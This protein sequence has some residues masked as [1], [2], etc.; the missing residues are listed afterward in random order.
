M[1]VRLLYRVIVKMYDMVVKNSKAW[2]HVNKALIVCLPFKKCMT[3]DK[4]RSYDLTIKVILSQEYGQPVN[5]ALYSRFILQC[6]CFLCIT[7]YKK[8]CH[9]LQRWP[10]SKKDCQHLGRGG[11]ALRY[12]K[13]DNS[14]NSPNGPWAPTGGERAVVPS[15]LPVTC[16][17][18]IWVVIDR[19]R[20]HLSSLTAVGGV[21]GSDRW[22]SPS[23]PILPS[24]PTNWLVNNDV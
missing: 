9:S 6:N 7:T 17:T 11:V 23:S 18:S 21:T 22:D 5:V 13:P 16:Q 15:K 12:A 3:A 10:A 20:S 19:R 14:V 1:L 2:S 4:K 24:Q 8:K